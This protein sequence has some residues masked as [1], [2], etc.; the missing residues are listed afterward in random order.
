MV[1]GGCGWKIYAHVSKMVHPSFTFMN[2]AS[3]S[4]SAADDAT[5]FKMVQRVNF[6]PLSV[7][8]STSL[9]NNTRKKWPDARLLLFLAED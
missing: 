2:I 6:S 1:V 4:A 8:C 5:K 3:N 7:M 9:E